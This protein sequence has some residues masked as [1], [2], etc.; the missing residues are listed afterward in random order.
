[1][2]EL[3]EARTIAKDLRN[4]ILNKRII[5]VRGNFEGHKFTF[6][7]KDPYAYK[8]QL[9]NKRITKIIP[10]NF[11]VEVVI[12]DYKLLM[13][14]GAVIRY[15]NKSEEEPKKSKL[16]LEFEDGSYLTITT[17]MY[18]CIMVLPKDEDMG[19]L[20]YQ[21]ERQ[22]I[23]PLDSEFTYHY[24]Q[25]LITPTTQKLSVKAFIATEQRILGIGN[26]TSQDIMFN[27][28]LHPKRKINTLD[29][30]DLHALYHAIVT[31]LT[32]MVTQNGRDTET[33][34]NGQKGSYKT[35]LSKNTYKSPCIVC[36][37]VL[38]K[39]QYLGGSIYYCPSC[40]KI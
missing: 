5:D 25:Q 29:S 16:L 6:Y 3:P 4:T 18:S 38:K 10:R 30:N 32:N 35:I 28:L 15:Y 21:I 24:F 31:T 19:N 37:G 20:Y 27:A 34:I 40:Q 8:E 12:E 26:G 2:I 36:H 11:Y 17:A 39:E 22:G 7:Y 13:R 1:M 23:S 9:I 14:D 33:R